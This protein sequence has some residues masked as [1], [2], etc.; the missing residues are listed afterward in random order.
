MVI[1]ELLGEVI[2][3]MLVD[4]KH[5]HFD[6]KCF[7]LSY[8]Y[9]GRDVVIHASSKLSLF[10]FYRSVDAWNHLPSNIKLITSLNS[11]K[12]AIKLF[13]LSAFLKCLLFNQL[14]HTV[15]LSVLLCCI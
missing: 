12:S 1:D 4:I 8:R 6:R 13:D 10:F 15:L 9:H 2:D 3:D 5:W 7:H 14:C 11:F